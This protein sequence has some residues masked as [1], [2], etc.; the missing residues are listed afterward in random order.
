MKVLSVSSG[1]ADVGILAPVWRALAYRAD[2]ELHVMLTGAHVS[3]DSTVR[4][5][6]PHGATGHTE[7][8][9]MGGRDGLA[10][11]DAMARIAAAA[12]RLGARIAPDR[13]LVMGDRL[14]MLPA[15]MG[16]VP[17]NVPLV[18][19][20][21]GELTYGAADDRVRHAITKLSH[22]HCT[23]NVEAAERIARMGEEAWRIRVTG[24]P[25][26]DSLVEAPVLDGAAFA[27]ELGLASIEGLR[28]VTVHPETNVTAPLAAVDAT[29]TALEATPGPSLITAPNA[30]PGGAE[31]RARIDAFVSKHG[32]AVFRETLGA[33]LYANALRHAA[34]M[35][36]N[37]SS[38]VIEAGLFGLPVINV[39]ERQGGRQR[40]A[41]VRDCAAHA[42]EVARML[43]G[44]LPRLPHTTP[45]GD[46]HAAA[47][48]AE[49]VTEMHGTARLLYKRFAAETQH[50]IAPWGSP[51]EADS[52]GPH[53]GI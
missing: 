15:V 53:G 24:A 48:V 42:D 30:D 11:S 6:L 35:V 37:S 29:L 10:A 39:G 44:V 19:L 36:G 20:H 46:G 7:G 28:L 40:G 52:A 12:G 23:A 27:R 25:G 49:A 5:A 47:R 45:Y 50:F 32:R 22:L 9:D 43:R 17:L 38:G 3:D 41:N 18:H 31:A 1:R 14:D 34:V 16:F 21:G 26:L 8:A 2:V 4:A 51:G 13:A 33:T